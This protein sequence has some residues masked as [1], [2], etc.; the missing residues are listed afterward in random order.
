MQSFLRTS[1]AQNETHSRNGNRSQQL[2][3]IFLAA[4]PESLKQ[5]RSAIG[6]MSN[7]RES[8][9]SGRSRDVYAHI[10]R[11]GFQCPAC[12]SLELESM[13]EDFSALT[14][15][16]A[17]PRWLKAHTPYISK[18]TV[19]YY[20]QYGAA[21]M[22]FF[23][24]FKLKNIGIGEVRGFQRWR[25]HVFED[26]DTAELPLGDELQN[27]KYRHGAGNVRIRNEINCV[28]KPILREAGV[29]ADIESK[30]FKHLPIPREGS[31]MALSKEQWREIFDIAFSNPRWH[32][33]GH[34]LR[35]MFRG[36]FGFGEIRKLK[37]KDVD[38]TKGTIRI[39]EGAKNGGSRVR[40]VALV[41]SALESVEWIVKRWKILGGESDDQY[42]LPLR[43]TYHK[44][45]DK[46]MT[47]IN[48]AWNAIKREWH[49]RSKVV[50][51]NPRQY[52]ARV[53]AASL[54]LSNSKLSLSTIEKALGWTPSSAM[55]KRYHRADLDN[56]RDALIT[57]EDSE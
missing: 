39:I 37:R 17:F 16:E 19:H 31:G 8:G 13:R 5:S 23:S 21:L 35:V 54:L 32:L 53:S 57:L 36:G 42:L 44:G 15:L 9:L 56:Q 48:F 2:N 10:H 24:S 49:S 3:G 18:N 43:A 55:R 41:P 50:T 26:N 6:S 33:A 46:P 27:S 52:D 47:S 20:E 30:K 34:C 45:L 28:L 7:L 25:S 22:P 1:N 12:A 14:F 11:E 40:T 51:L 38:L 29:W 4:K